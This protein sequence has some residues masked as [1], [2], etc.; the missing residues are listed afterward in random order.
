MTEAP[1]PLEISVAQPVLD[2]LAGRLE[3]TRWPS[4]PDGLG[5]EMGADFEYLRALC[6]HWRTTYDWR[7]IEQALNGLSNWTW[8]GI[9]FVWERAQRDDRGVAAPQRLP[10]LMI[11][12]WPGGPIEFLELIPRLVAAGHDVVVPSL[13]GFAF[14]VEPVRPMNVVG[15]ADRLCALMSEGLGYERYAVQGG[16][17]GSEI[18]ARMAFVDAESVAAFHTNAP[19]VLPPPGEFDPPLSEEEQSFLAQAQR[20]TARDGVHLLVQGYVPDAMAPGLADS[21]AGLAAWLVDKFRRWSDSDGD[22]EQRFSKDDLC[23]FL[24]LYWAT[25]TI[26]SSLRLY[27]AEAR[28]RWRL[29]PGDRITVPTAVADFPKELVRPPRTWTERQLADIRR[30]TEMA[31]GGHFAAIEEPELLADDLIE[32]LA[33]L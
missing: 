33:E 4:Q 30:W 19:M 2:D 16:D 7:Q 22:V 3:R 12:G 1:Q 14:S 6:D 27:G 28:E 10:V 31:R 20:W 5:W 32:F 25:G 24:T 26:G 17:W 11:H 29:A 15:I 18:G 13:P 8:E 9:H 23:D 21:P